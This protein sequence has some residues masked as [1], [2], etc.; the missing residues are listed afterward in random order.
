MTVREEAILICQIAASHKGLPG[1]NGYRHIGQQLDASQEA[2]D[3]ALE[4]FWTRPA[5]GGEP[6]GEG[7][8]WAVEA[9]LWAQELL[10]AGWS[11]G[12]PVTDYL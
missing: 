9:D 11:P 4:A 2:I 8:F 10:E 3:L 5:G 1:Q 6:T 7:R 12:E